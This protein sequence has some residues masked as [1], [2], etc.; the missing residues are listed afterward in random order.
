MLGSRP[1][2]AWRVGSGRHIVEPE[3]R[4]LLDDV[5]L[6]SDVTGAP[7]R[8]G[9]ALAVD[10]EP[11]APQDRVLLLGGVSMPITASVRSGRKRTTG[12]SGSS[13]WTSAW[14]TQLAPGELDDNSVASFA[15]CSAR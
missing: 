2:I 6:A 1:N 3:A 9:D 12:G 15:A 14:P 7:R 5:D 8:H 13:S 10:A 4:D 11:E